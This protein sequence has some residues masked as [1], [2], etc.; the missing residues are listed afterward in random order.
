MRKSSLENSKT[1]SK[2]RNTM[3]NFISTIK[4]IGVGLGLMYFLDP[5]RGRRRRALV[6]DQFVRVGTDLRF[7]LQ[8]SEHDTRNRLRGVFAEAMALVSGGGA[9]DYIIEER[10]RANI[11]RVVRNASAIQVT[12]DGG[13]VALHGPVLARDLSRLLL[14][15]ASTRGVK[16]IDNHLD[17]HE[18]PKNIPGL[19]GADEPME[20]T[21]ELMKENW[22]PATR[23]LTGAG[24]SAIALRGLQRGGLLG[25]LASLSGLALALRGIS[26]ME[27][28]RLVG[29]S[30][31]EHGIDIQKAINV[32]APVARVFEFWS[33]FTNFPRFMSH[34]EEV[35]DLGNG[36]SHWVV[37]GPAGVPIEWIAEITDYKDNEQIAW[38]SQRNETVEHSGVVQFQSNQDG[39][40]RVTVR[41]TY[42]P[43]AGVLGHAVAAIFGVDP[44]Q[45]MDEDLMRFKSLIE[46]G[47]TTTEGEEISREEVMAARQSH[48]Y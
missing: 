41:M 30:G 4:G 33:N 5:D 12:A 13:R 18:S 39:G 9:P 19:Q 23:L 47:K 15:A 36:R 7:A 8:V 27:L 35:R 26:N 24:G 38:R 45:A 22:A 42:T 46:L 16:G 20:S 2:E 14:Q 37:K 44:K 32:K 25:T 3:S 34:V 31:R 40:T 29:M 28:S 1:K 17:V 10:V 11:G 21:F 6:R 43:P 48:T